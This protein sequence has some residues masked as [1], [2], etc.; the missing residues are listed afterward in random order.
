MRLYQHSAKCPVALRTFLD[1][2][3]DYW[4]FIPLLW[5]DAEEANM[6][7]L[8]E[9]SNL[10]MGMNHNINMSVR[11]SKRVSDYLD[12]VPIPPAAYAFSYRQ[13]QQ[14]RSFFE[15]ILTLTIHQQPF[16]TLDLYQFSII[17]VRK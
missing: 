9:A 11:H 13:R 17:T 2:N 7:Y 1:C 3:P 8:R 6:A 15:R 12:M 16:S 5:Q 14:Q 10:N 4:C